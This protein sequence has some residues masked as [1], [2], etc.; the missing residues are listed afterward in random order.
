M[1][2]KIYVISCRQDLAAIGMDRLRSSVDGLDE[3]EIKLDWSKTRLVPVVAA[4]KTHFQEGETRVVEIK[5]IYISAN[6]FVLQS[7]YGSN[8]MGH[9][10]CIGAMEFKKHSED[11]V[12]NVGMFQSRIKASVFP[13]DLLGQILIIAGEK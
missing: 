1:T 9:L 13:G 8:G 4:T 5:P 11:R 3:T 7:F 2:E 10:N 6:S 12:A